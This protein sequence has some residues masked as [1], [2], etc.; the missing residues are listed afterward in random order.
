M[1]GGSLEYA[2]THPEYAQPTQ[3]LRDDVNLYSGR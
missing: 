3:L 2:A 1:L